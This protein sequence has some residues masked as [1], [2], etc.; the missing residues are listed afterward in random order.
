MPDLAAT[1]Q[2]VSAA[3]TDRA[4]NDD[5]LPLIAG[6]PALARDRLAIYRANIAAN[7][8]LALAAIYP[9]VR[10]LVG[11]EFF[12]GLA[13]AYCGAHPSVSGDLN[14]L[15]ERLADFVRTFPP[16]QSLPYLPDV[17]RLEWLAHQAHYAADHAPLDAGRLASIREDDYPRL[18]LTLH[19]AVATLTS[20]YPLYRIWEVHQ[21]DYRGD[22]AVD[23]GSGA[24][25]VVVYRPQFHV[26]V[27]KLLRGGGEISQCAGARR[28]ARTRPGALATAEDTGFDLAASLRRWTVANIVVGLS[29]GV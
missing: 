14:E 16:A 25:Q 13:H 3:L 8:A 1:Q 2:L 29:V 17:A 22:I 24:E 9:I 19:P 27:A 12:D 4:R 21:D 23:L 7:A 26:A 5:A 6:D 10:K 20:A 28:T 18:A 11:A 15:G